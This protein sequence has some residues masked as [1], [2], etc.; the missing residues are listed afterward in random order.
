M[1]KLSVKAI[2]KY[3]KCIL[4]SLKGTKNENMDLIDKYEKVWE[5]IA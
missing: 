2:V 5:I 3:I 4:S 1:S